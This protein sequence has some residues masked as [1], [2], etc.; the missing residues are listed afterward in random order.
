MATFN[1]YINCDNAAFEDDGLP[2]AV[3]H[4]LRYLAYH[5]EHRGELDTHAMGL[6]RDINGNTVGSWEFDPS[7]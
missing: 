5:I 4:I 2:H 7:E 3:G 6:L 1:V